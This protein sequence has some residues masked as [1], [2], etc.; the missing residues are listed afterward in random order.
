MSLK[1]K[2]TSN[3]R[4]IDS[5]QRTEQ[6]IP[7]HKSFNTQSMLDGHNLERRVDRTKKQKA[8]SWTSNRISELY[9]RRSEKSLSVIW[10]IKPFGSNKWDQ[11]SSEYNI[12]SLSE[13]RKERDSDYLKKYYT[14][15]VRE[16]LSKPTGDPHL[17]WELY[18]VKLMRQEIDGLLHMGSIEDSY[19]EE[20]YEG[21]EESNKL[22]NRVDIYL[23]KDNLI[24]DEDEEGPHDQEELTWNQVQ[25]LEPEQ[26]K[27]QPTKT[28]RSSTDLETQEK[29]PKV[30]MS[31]ERHS[32]QRSSTSTN[33]NLFLSQM[34]AAI[35]KDLETRDSD[36]E[37]I[38]VVRVALE[39]CEARYQLLEEENG[40]LKEEIVRI[41]I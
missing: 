9:R 16:G 12:I 26:G 33:A 18:E 21:T 36:S 3:N 39:K 20:L 19:N 13:K 8:K 41:R 30:T 6:I 37:A 17:N 7:S 29:Y 23:G 22:D 32:R 31:I 28:T 27:R 11:V 2:V 24:R 35:E 4:R 14:D 38:Q 25:D 40:R 5:Q 15:K 34:A 1:W 10:K